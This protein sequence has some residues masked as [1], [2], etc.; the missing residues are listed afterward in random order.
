[1]EKQ[2]V[3]SEEKQDTKKTTFDILF[4]L[5]VNS[6]VETKNGLSYLSWSWAWAEIKKKYPDAMYSV[7]RFGENN[8]PYLYDEKL[9]YIVFTRVNIEGQEYEM[10]LPVMDGANKAML[11]HEYTY[12]GKKKTWNNAIRQYEFTEE[13]KKVAKAS[14]YDINKTIMRCLVKNLAMF[15]LGLYIYS[16]EDLPEE[17]KE[18]KQKET[19][20]EIKKATPNQ[21]ALLKKTYKGDNLKKLLEANNIKDI[22]DLPLEKANEIVAKI[23]ELNEANKEAK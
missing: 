14:M 2:Y 10:W 21:V 17:L 4:N 8:T 12:I 23:K 19:E 6:K 22:K 7:E 11:D 18:D 13:E 3:D 5:D 9:G 16:G 1:M 15:G 20:E